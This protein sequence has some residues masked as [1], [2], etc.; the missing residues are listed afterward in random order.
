MSQKLTRS[1]DRI[2]AGV[3]GGIAKYLGVDASIVRIITAAVV[4]FTGV[5]PLLYIVAWLIL[6]EENTGRTGIDAITGGVK[7]AKESYD[8]NKMPNSN[9]LR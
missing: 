1:S 5:G 8:T 3:A 2:I 9:D 4:L 6:P 7:K